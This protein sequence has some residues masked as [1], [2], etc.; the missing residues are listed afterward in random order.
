MDLA[1]RYLGLDLVSPLV[2]SASPLGQDSDTVE[3]LADQGVGALVMNSLFEEII[4]REELVDSVLAEAG[5]DIF[6]EATSYLPAAETGGSAVA[7]YM[8]QLERAVQAS[9]MPVIGSIN[10]ATPGFWVDAARQM[11]DAGVSAIELNIYSVPDLHIK[12]S[13]V[14]EY[15]LDILTLVKHTV[16]VPVAVKLSPFF[17]STGAMAMSLDEAGADGLVLFNRFQQPDIDI[18]RMTVSPGAFLSRS[19]DRLLPQTWIALL[20]GEIRASLAATSGV[21]RSED[22][23][24]YLLAGA[25]VV[26]SASALLRHGPGYA[27][28]LLNGLRAW[29]R[30]KGVTRVDEIRGRLAVGDR[31]DRSD[32]DRTGYVTALQQAQVTWPMR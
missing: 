27:G 3:A 21:E 7:R 15:H 13:A 11:V 32:Y 17:S 20:R 30:R 4:R 19:R 10:G 1:T 8:R 5:S 6:G 14:E 2:A 16:D 12:G 22:M 24:R 9:D 23:V 31:V 26:M 18:E 29:M 28:E 25:D